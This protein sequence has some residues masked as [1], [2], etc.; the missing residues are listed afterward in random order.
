MTRNDTLL[1]LL[2]FFM[3]MVSFV[4]GV[5]HDH[6]KIDQLN[7]QRIHVF[8]FNLCTGCTI[9]LL[10][11]KEIKKHWVVIFLLFSILFSVSAAINFFFVAICSALILTAIVEFARVKSYSFFP[12]NFFSLKI[13]VSIKFHHA[14]LLCLSFALP[15]SAFSMFAH[16][17]KIHLPPKMTVDIFFLGFSFPV[18]L[19]VMS[20]LFANMKDVEGIV[21]LL[22]RNFIFWIVNVGV[23][24]FFIFILAE[25]EILQVAIALLLM[26]SVVMVFICYYKHALREKQ[27][28][29][30]FS[31]VFFLLLSALSGVLYVTIKSLFENYHGLGI[32]YIL[33]LH[34]YVSLYGWNQAG[35][36]VLLW[37]N[38]KYVS[39]I[40]NSKA[41]I[42]LHW[43]AVAV[44]APCALF[45]WAFAAMAVVLYV[46]FLIIVYR[47]T[48]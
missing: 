25:N 40:S 29:F 23:I 15:L 22:I 12:S 46:S 38:K 7:I 44:F 16:L 3:M 6:I 37:D 47:H 2:L 18:S 45:H 11:L 32:R 10:H 34:R 39:P 8:L 42:A 30:L 43:L 13:P 36:I 5:F 4:A 9:L 19:M 14:A 28:Y 33:S 48:A 24:V 35:I 1:V 31:S 26:V 41:M 21:E 20:V 27:F 17:W